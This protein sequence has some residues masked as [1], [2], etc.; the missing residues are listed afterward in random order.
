MTA[1]M[2]YSY[3]QPLD[4]ATIYREWKHILP[5]AMALAGTAGYI[6]SIV[7]GFFAT[8]VSHMSGAVSHLGLDI[9]QGKGHQAYTSLL[10]IIGFLF[11]SVLAGMFV[12]ATKLG[13]SRRYGTVL[14]LEGVLLL[15][16]TLLL[17][18][19]SVEGTMLAATACGLQNA[20]SSS[21]CGLMI[22]TTHVSGI[23]T[24][25]GVM[26]GHW[27][28]HRRIVTWKL[29][30]LVALLVSFGMGGII[31]ASLNM[32]YGP[33]CLLIAATGCFIAGAIFFML[34]QQNQNEI[35]ESVLPR[36]SIFPND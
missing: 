33:A 17:L 20:M 9:A 19:N 35:E 21:Y 14:M 26:L 24:D 27:L 31:G 5:G 7:L 6:N 8:P 18:R 30:F 29:K 36:T 11:G 12:G 10:I 15:G 1:P 16:S 4:K 23:V 32:R 22:R 25:M 2:P 28:R 3:P 13:P 34:M